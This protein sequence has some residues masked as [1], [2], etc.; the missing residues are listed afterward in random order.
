MKRGTHIISTKVL[1]KNQLQFLLNAGFSVSMADFIDITLLPFEITSTPDVLLFTS[2][3]AVKSILQN[4]KELLLKT[5]Q[6]LCVG[7]KTKS[8]LEKS[9][10]QVLYCTEYAQDLAPII[11]EHFTQKNI[12]FFTGNLRS[13]ILPDCM[14]KNHISYTE[15]QVYQN[16][17]SPT[18]MA[19][20][21]DALLFFSPSA[22]SSY[23]KKN[24]IT[25]EVCFC[26][27]T[28]T[29]KALESTTKNIVI[30]KRQTVENVIIQ[31]IQYYQK[32]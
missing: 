5:P 18:H 20:T 9:G 12:A 26:I 11:Q 16:E 13:H 25:H 14:K 19:S 2:Q 8:L 6:A 3:N 31:C 21:A 7:T 17:A 32:H 15:Y 1:Q 23:L 22:I 10:C 30:A 29:A 28:T 24:K 4:N 27:G